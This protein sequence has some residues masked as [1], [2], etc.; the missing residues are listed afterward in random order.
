MVRTVIGLIVTSRRA[1]KFATSQ[2]K[3]AK[4]FPLAI[5]NRGSDKPCQIHP[6]INNL[7][8]PCHTESR[9]EQK[10]IQPESLG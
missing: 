5:Q 3:I 9:S 10:A 8:E 6:T 4:E 1:I 7:G 2:R